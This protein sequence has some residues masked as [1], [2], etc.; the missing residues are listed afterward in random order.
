MLGIRN[1][2][3]KRQ[4]TNIQ[5]SQ[6]VISQFTK[7]RA[8]GGEVCGA[9][10]RGPEFNAQNPLNNLD[11]VSYACNSITGREGVTAGSRVLLASLSG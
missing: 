6:P 7:M 4:E 8:W 3:G 1:P 11:V 10:S 5:I 9:Q 2:W